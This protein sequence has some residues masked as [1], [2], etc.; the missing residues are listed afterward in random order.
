MNSYLELFLE[1]LRKSREDVN[2]EKL[3]VG[4]K[5]LDRHK[6]R[7][8]LISDSAG[9]HVDEENIY[10][11]VV[12]G[13]SISQRPQMQALLTRIEDPNVKG[14][15]VI[16][17]QRLCRGDLGD[18]DRIIKTFKYTHTLIL[19]PEKEYN[20]DN[21]SDEEY[22]ID[23]L[24]YS[25]K[26]YNNIKKRL[27]EGGNDSVRAG[28]YVGSHPAY[29]YESYKL[30][31]QR[32]HSLKIIEEQA[33]VVRLIFKLCIDGKGTLAIA[34]YLNNLSIPSPNGKK[35]RK[36]GIREMLKNEIYMGKVFRGKRKIVTIIE[37]G[38]LKKKTIRNK[39]GE[40]LEN[41]GKHE[42]II[43]EEDF[44]LAQERLKESSKKYVKPG[45]KLENPLAG[46]VRCSKCG[47]VMSRRGGGKSYYY[48]PKGSGKNKITYQNGPLLH[49]TNKCVVSSPLYKVEA[50][51]IEALKIWLNENKKILME[52]KKNENSI[53]NK[54]INEI[55]LLNKE[56]EK[57]KNKMD[58]LRDLLEDGIYDKKTYL[59][60]SK[61][62]E[63]S[64]C[65]IE[66]KI[67]KITQKNEQIKMNKIESLIPKVES[68]IEKYFDLGIEDRNKMLKGIL[69]RVDYTKTKSRSESDLTLDL[70]PKI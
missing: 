61:I 26:E 69:E 54:V 44:L 24:S 17:V 3:N 66:S 67:T 15:W 58:R 68:C 16:D 53:A 45:T 42:S 62:V 33:E 36:N 60:R 4:Y 28:C 8:K 55:D 43:S 50:A 2:Y 27:I 7:L 35:W 14:V 38:E 9:K 25:R 1:Y 56:L 41:I 64:I 65:M 49:C 32:G 70:Y 10:E 63:E 59:E 51:L 22:L 6:E 48:V 13:D 40:Y 39:K 57:E 46:I 47:L 20:L 19:T 34:N 52:Y 11:E 31:G 12:S 37:N 23:K 5:T 29:G 30:K 18:Q 21:P